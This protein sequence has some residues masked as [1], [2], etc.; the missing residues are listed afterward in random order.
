MNRL[1]DKDLK[2]RIEKSKALQEMMYSTSV[3]HGGGGG[4]SIFNKVYKKGMSDEE[5]IKAVYAE[6][7]AEGGQRHFASSSEKERAGVVNRFGREQADILALLKNP[8]LATAGATAPKPP[9]TSAAS[10]AAAP[11]RPPVTPTATAVTSTIAPTTPV[12]VPGRTTPNQPGTGAPG[13]GGATPANEIAGALERL[14]SMTAQLVGYNKDVAETSRLQLS[15]IK[16]I[17][18]VY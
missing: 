11:P 15:A 16:S 3:Q 14:N 8:E 12:A 1:N 7:G 5:L 6:R 17:G 10:T 2:A 13:A 4:A 18:K 9:T